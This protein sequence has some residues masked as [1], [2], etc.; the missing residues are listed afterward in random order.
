MMTPLRP[1]SF[2][3]LTPSMQ[4]VKNLHYGRYNLKTAIMTNGAGHFVAYFWHDVRVNLDKFD[5]PFNNW[6]EQ[7]VLAGKKAY[8]ELGLT[9]PPDITNE[10]I[11]AEYV[12]MCKKLS[13][14]TDQ[15]ERKHIET[16]LSIFLMAHLS[17]LKKLSRSECNRLCAS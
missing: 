3:A 8:R 2:K 7:L 15:V 10:Q 6:C 12:D 5:T 11:Q 13:Q 16:R 4:P 17:T 14:S 9:P 1:L